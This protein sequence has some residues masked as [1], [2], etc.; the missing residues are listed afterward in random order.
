MVMEAFIGWLNRLNLSREELADT[1]EYLCMNN[2]KLAF[3]LVDLTGDKFW[4]HDTFLKTA[5][6][7]Q[8]RGKIA[9]AIEELKRTVKE[10]F[11]NLKNLDK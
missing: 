9:V 3:D 2:H 1:L 4:S 6:Y 10:M 11:E 5:D 8:K 7:V